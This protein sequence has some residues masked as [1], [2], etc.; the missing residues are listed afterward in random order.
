[1]TEVHSAFR[2]VGKATYGRATDAVQDAALLKQIVD[3]LDRAAKEIE[4][5]AR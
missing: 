2:K 1:M 3:I 4:A 5:L